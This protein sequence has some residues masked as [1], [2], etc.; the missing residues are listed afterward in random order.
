[1]VSFEVAVEL[2]TILEVI[3]RPA[4]HSLWQARGCTAKHSHGV[5]L[6]CMAPG[7]LSRSI[8]YLSSMAAGFSQ[9]VSTWDVKKG[10]K[11]ESLCFI[12][13]DTHFFYHILFQRQGTRS[14]PHIKEITLHVLR[15]VLEFVNMSLT[16]PYAFP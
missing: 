9:T 10:D 14:I 16:S 7:S 15:R 12:L 6:G 1:M 5:V 3:T 13:E 4:S 2:L 11:L 8:E